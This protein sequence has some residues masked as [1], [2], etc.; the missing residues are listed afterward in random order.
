MFHDNGLYWKL[1]LVAAQLYIRALFMHIHTC[2]VNGMQSSKP[3]FFFFLNQLSHSRLLRSQKYSP[4][5]PRLAPLSLCVLQQSENPL[6]AQKCFL[7]FFQ[8]KC[9]VPPAATSALLFW[10]SWADTVGEYH[11]GPVCYILRLNKINALTL[12]LLLQ[13]SGLGVSAGIWGRL[14]LHSR[15][16][17]SGGMG[18]PD[19][20]PSWN[21][22]TEKLV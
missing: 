5:L 1:S 10:K 3:C 6:N 8:Y 15:G 2:I 18:G 9:C 20:C 22:K 13:V 19:V 4:I 17:S 7:A 21:G 16:S 14:A 11:S 12:M